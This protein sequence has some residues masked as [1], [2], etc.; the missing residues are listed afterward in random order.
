MKLVDITNFK[1]I[2][3]LILYRLSHTKMFCFVCLF[4]CLF[5]FYLV[6]LYLL[7]TFRRKGAFVMKWRIESHSLPQFKLNIRVKLCRVVEFR[8]YCRHKSV[9]LIW[10][11]KLLHYSVFSRSSRMITLFVLSPSSM[12]LCRTS[13][14]LFLCCHNIVL[15]TT[16]CLWISEKI[17]IKIIR[18][19]FHNVA[20]H[21]VLS[22][23][24]ANKPIYHKVCISYDIFDVVLTFLS[25]LVFA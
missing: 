23:G 3:N 22:K 5:V 20:N 18:S 7:E 14:C 1:M 10:V 15:S 9:L 17:I 8:V 12:S 13:V 4:V 16:S 24:H 6:F 11:K 2:P 25:C 19:Y 21:I